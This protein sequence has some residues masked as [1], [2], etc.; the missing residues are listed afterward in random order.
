MRYR[1]VYPKEPI[2]EP[3]EQLTKFAHPDNELVR[4][5]KD[6]LEKLISAANVK[7]G[8]PSHSQTSSNP[9]AHANPTPL[10]PPKTKGRKRL[11]ETE[12]P[13]SGLD[14]DALLK[15]EPKRTKIS[16]ENAIPEFKQML[17]RADSIE[18]IH[19]AVKQMTSVI[20][21]QIKH[22][23]GDANYDRVVEGL[24]TMR[25]ELVDYEEPTLYNDYLG[26]LKGKILGEELGG[27]RNELWWLIR[28]SK[29]GLIDQATSEVSKVTEDEAKEVSSNE[30]DK[31]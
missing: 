20:E 7:K 6:S 15:Q 12:K 19:D 2:L 29:L 23:L 21:T 16:A 13:L 24:G 31:F 11:R 22:S 5:A 25:E 9:T 3:S 8:E 4:G 27:D 17:S 28:K 30:R 18:I 1:A 26:A 10:V 14:V